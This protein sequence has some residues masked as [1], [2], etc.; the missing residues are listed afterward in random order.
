MA[1]Y[2]Y[3]QA[4]QSHPNVVAKKHKKKKKIGGHAWTAVAIR[5][6]LVAAS[7]HTTFD[8]SRSSFSQKNPI[9]LL[10]D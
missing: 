5:F 6:S 10:R 1:V 4:V 9:F 2:G 8:A 7:S 3:D